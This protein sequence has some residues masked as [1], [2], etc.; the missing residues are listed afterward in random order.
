M[1]ARLLLAVQ[2]DAQA[3]TAY[4]RVINTD[5]I[6]VTIRLRPAPMTTARAAQPLLA[7]RPRS[8]ERP[9]G[10]A[11][12][13]PAGSNRAEGSSDL[14]RTTCSYQVVRTGRSPA[15]TASTRSRSLAASRVM[16]SGGSMI[17]SAR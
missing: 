13:H 11:L 1:L 14:P 2:P 8:P 16:V 4:V 15:L 6:M 3:R 17:T 10:P 7:A 5:E 12:W 9:L